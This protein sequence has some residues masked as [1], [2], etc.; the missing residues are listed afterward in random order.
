MLSAL[1]I[2]LLR[3]LSSL[4]TAEA[5]AN[6]RLECDLSISISRPIIPMYV[7]EKRFGRSKATSALHETRCY[8]PEG[9]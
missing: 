8:Q 3:G 9:H 5:V 1:R 7:H 6:D 2:R 4:Q